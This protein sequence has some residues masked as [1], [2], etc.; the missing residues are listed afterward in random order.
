MRRSS[1]REEKDQTPGPGGTKFRA[2]AH[3]GSSDVNQH[4]VYHQDRLT[5]CVFKFLNESPT[6]ENQKV[7]FTHKFQFPTAPEKSETLT[8]LGTCPAAAM[9]GRS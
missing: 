1:L 3:A 9:M 6:F 8:M 7:S 4:A 2:G 5:I